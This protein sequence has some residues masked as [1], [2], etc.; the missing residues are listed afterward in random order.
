MMFV[1]RDEHVLTARETIKKV[2]G[3]LDKPNS[4]IMFAVPI[5]YVEGLGE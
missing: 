5:T 1:L 2:I 3:T 4:A